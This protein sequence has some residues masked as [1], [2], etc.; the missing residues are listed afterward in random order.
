MKQQLRKRWFLFLLLIGLTL[1]WFQP[2][3]LRPA[4]ERL[5]LRIIVAAALFIMAWSL[6]SRSLFQSIVRPLPA[7]WA[8]ILSYGPLP[9]LAWSAGWLMPES[10][11]RLG[12][13]II[14]SVPCTLSSAVLWTRM[15]G[16]ND[17][18]AL[19]AVFLTTATSWLA[20]PLWLTLGASADTSL[21]MGGMMRSLVF[22][23][24]VPVALGQLS[25]AVRPMARTAMRYQALL[26]TVSRLFILSIILKAV[27]DVR[28]P[29]S[30]R[31]ALLPWS[32]IGVAAA[33]CIG[34]HL[35]ALAGGLWSSRLLGFDRA[36]QIAVAFAGSQKT[37]PVALYLFDVYF[38]A[39]YPLAILPMVI[40]HVGQLIVDTLI[41]EGLARHWIAT[42]PAARR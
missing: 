19:L 12:L 28:Q 23:L 11:L 41:A 5:E 8:S 1:A 9:A 6:E 25:R 10:D 27:V 20:T 40:Y 4:T 26:A 42:R 32:S 24:I 13:L 35:L 22:V 30:E 3:W 15:A 17:A 16:G 36:A 7:V 14:A 34:V 18:T 31:S 33:L 37:L 21:D 39:S 29:L 38:Q 2:Q